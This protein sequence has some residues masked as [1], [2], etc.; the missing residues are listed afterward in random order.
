[1]KIKED[2]ATKDYKLPVV[3]DDI[4]PILP[5]Q[6][7]DDGTKPYTNQLYDERIQNFWKDINGIL[8]LLNSNNKRYRISSAESP[9]INS[10]LL[11]RI[12]EE[13]KKQDV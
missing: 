10:Y 7:I 3:L 6:P 11:W 4:L 8:Q 5:K 9:L 13:I 1:M 2:R 12:L